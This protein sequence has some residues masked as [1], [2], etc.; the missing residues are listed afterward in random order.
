M[1][2]ILPVSPETARAHAA[3]ANRL[4]HL[5]M[6]YVAAYVEALLS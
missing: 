5:S 2:Q 4:H 6:R 3:A 1:A